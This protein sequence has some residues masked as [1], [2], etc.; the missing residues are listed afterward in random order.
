MRGATVISVDAVVNVQLWRQYD[1][2][3]SRVVQSLQHRRGCPWAKDI[4]PGITRLQECFPHLCLN[5]GANEVLLLHGTT[6]ENAT[7]IMREGFDDRLTHRHLYGRGVYF[8]TDTPPDK[9]DVLFCFVV[10]LNC[11]L[12]SSMQF[13]KA[14]LQ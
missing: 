4:A 2:K 3:R 12:C 1:F 14:G 5:V 10:F 9:E 8:T 11:A 6:E 13:A 7:S